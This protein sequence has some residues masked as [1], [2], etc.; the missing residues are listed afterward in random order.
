MIPYLDAGKF[1]VMIFNNDVVISDIYINEML[2]IDKST[3]SINGVHDPIINACFLPDSD[4]FVNLF[5][6]VT[7]VNWHFKFSYEQ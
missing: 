7:R 3:I 2:G 1:R 4:I 6:K 5:H